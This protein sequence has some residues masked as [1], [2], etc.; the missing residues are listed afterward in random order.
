MTSIPSSAY[1]LSAVFRTKNHR[2]I[3]MIFCYNNFMSIPS[4]IIVVCWIVFILYWFISSFSVKRDIGGGW[5]EEWRSG[6]WVRLT[7]VVV[8]IILFHFLSP[9]S[10]SGRN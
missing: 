4:L 9:G 5:G 1:L 7:I 6:W 8:I 3:S 2:F 10:F